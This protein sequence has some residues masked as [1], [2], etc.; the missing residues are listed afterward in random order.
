MIRIITLLFL[1]FNY[2]AFTNQSPI[3][4]EI[5]LLLLVFLLDLAIR[6]EPGFLVAIVG[7]TLHLSI[8]IVILLTQVILF[9]LC[10]LK[11]QGQVF[12]NH[13]I[14][15]SFLGIIASSAIA[16]VLTQNQLFVMLQLLACGGAAVFG[17]LN[18]KYKKQQQ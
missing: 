6:M 9:S 15:L 13:Y 17:V 14:F 7:K 5:G 3:S 18:T 12:V 8:S 10:Y 1:L 11:N 2:R 16:F 4:R